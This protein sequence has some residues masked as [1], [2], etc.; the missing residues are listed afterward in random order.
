MQHATSYHAKGARL[1]ALGLAVLLLLVVSGCANPAR[2]DKM[3]VEAGAR[4]GVAADSALYQA[5]TIAD[6]RGG[7][8]TDRYWGYPAIDNPEIEGALR[9]S[10]ANHAMLADGRGRL[11]LFVTLVEFIRP[12]GG[13]DMTVMTAT[14]YRLTEAASGRAVFDETLVTY[15]I[16]DFTSHL[17]GVEAKLQSDQ[18][19]GMVLVAPLFLNLNDSEQQEIDALCERNLVLIDLAEK[20]DCS[21]LAERQAAAPAEPLACTACPA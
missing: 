4:G 14:H 1:S 17:I 15:F 7:L 13:F 10:L 16:A 12:A 19:I 21:R 5:V 18:N 9:L 11:A 8:E 20:K 6:V 3:A 2:P